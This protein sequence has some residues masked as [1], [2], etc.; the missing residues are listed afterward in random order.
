MF[1][2][3]D[4]ELS[5]FT[6]LLKSLLYP[7]YVLF[8]TLGVYWL[9][10]HPTA[11]QQAAKAS[12]ASLR[13]RSSLLGGGVAL[14]PTM[15]AGTVAG[16]LTTRGREGKFRATSTEAFL[17]RE[18]RVRSHRSKKLPVVVGVIIAWFSPHGPRQLNHAPP[19]QEL[20][21]F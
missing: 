20:W 14:L 3:Q 4:I 7:V 1:P 8:Q 21:R 5:S 11:N 2:R 16:A 6:F 13:V 9:P 15:G 19:P 12:L 18:Q 10:N 17:T